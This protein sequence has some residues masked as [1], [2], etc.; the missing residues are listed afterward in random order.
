M[1]GEKQGKEWRKRW[2]LIILKKN[3]GI[4]RNILDVLALFLAY[5]KL[6]TITVF[7]GPCSFSLY[8]T[9]LHHSFLMFF[10]SLF[11]IIS[12]SSLFQFFVFL[13]LPHFVFYFSCS[14][15]FSSCLLLL[16][17]SSFIFYILFLIF[18]CFYFPFPFFLI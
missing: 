11:L 6:Y 9:F 1:W 15:L 14:C 2:K 13:Y 8:L 3:I 17:F 4:M 5:L 7:Y 16:H 18:Y 12:F 10:S